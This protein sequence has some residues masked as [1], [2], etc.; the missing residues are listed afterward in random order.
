MRHS[1]HGLKVEE[2]VSYRRRQCIMMFKIVNNI[3]RN[4]LRTFKP[5][6]SVHLY[7]TRSAVRDNLNPQRACL[8]YKTWIFQFEA[9]RLWNNL[10][11]DIR[12]GTIIDSFKPKYLSWYFKQR[13]NSKFNSKIDRD[14]TD[15]S[16][17]VFLYHRIGLSMLYKFNILYF[18]VFNY[19]YIVHIHVFIGWA[20]METSYADDVTKGK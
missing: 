10:N 3:A 19:I 16:A 12:Q 15:F 18:K 2:K 1:T 5:I 11:T 6:S 17:S 13:F 8:K 9:S 14:I 7:K 20:I 4:Y